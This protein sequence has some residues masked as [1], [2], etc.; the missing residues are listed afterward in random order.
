MSGDLKIDNERGSASLIRIFNMWKNG[1]CVHFFPR[2]EQTKKHPTKLEWQTYVNFIHYFTPWKKVSIHL[3]ASVSCFLCCNSKLHRLCLE[4]IL[5][6]AVN[7]VCF[8]RLFFTIYFFVGFFLIWKYITSEHSQTYWHRCPLDRNIK[9]HKNSFKR[10]FSS[11][12]PSRAFTH[13]F[14]VCCLADCE[15]IASSSFAQRSMFYRI[16]HW[17]WQQ[18]KWIYSIEPILNHIW[19]VSRNTFCLQ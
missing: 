12:L 19:L 13:F 3:T 9:E 2:I 18:I 10:F 16:V 11:F 17:Q 5:L 4:V 6:Y 7:W 1:A 14:C 15:Q 8:S